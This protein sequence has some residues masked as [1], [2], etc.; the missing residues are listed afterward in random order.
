MF[1]RPFDSTASFAATGDDSALNGFSTFPVSDLT[2]SPEGTGDPTRFNGLT[3]QFLN[4][5]SQS[6]RFTVGESGQ[7]RFDYLFDGGAYQGELALFNLSGLESLQPGSTAFIQEA[8]RRSL[9]GSEL[10]YVVIQDG[11]EGA[12][13]SD[14]LI[15]EGNLNA[16]SYLGTKLFS[17]TPGTQ[18][19]L[20]LVP[21]GTVQA[22]FDNPA[23]DGSAHP[24]F[25]LASANFGS[26][27]QLGQ[28]SDQG[29]RSAIFAWEDLQV[30]GT[31]DRDFNDLVF[32]LDGAIGGVPTL[33]SLINPVKDWRESEVG[34]QIAASEPFNID[35]VLGDGFTE[36]QKAIINAAKISVES[37]ITQGL[38]DVLVE[39]Q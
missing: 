15:E 37:M 5:S 10:G 35:L 13:F 9:S 7:L 28:V 31:S 36:S 1:T 12:K 6:G 27:V 29:S 3:P 4:R 23:V 39:G 33:D 20:M 18:F 25:S 24:L 8:A 32:R 17:L 21:N 16:G 2:S 26:A 11:V 38:P 30:N 34:Q 22:V 19:G 14:G